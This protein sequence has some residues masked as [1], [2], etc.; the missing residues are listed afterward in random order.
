MYFWIQLLCILVLDGFNGM[1]IQSLHILEAMQRYVRWFEC[2]GSNEVGL[3][4][5]PQTNLDSDV[6]EVG[7]LIVSSDLKN[8][9][10]DF[11]QK[12]CN[13]FNVN[14]FFNTLF[15]FGKN[16]KQH[17]RNFQQCIQIYVYIYYIMYICYVMLCYVM[18]C[19][20]MLCYVMLCYVMLCY[21]MLCYVMLCYVMLC[22]VMLCYVYVMLCYVMLCYVIQ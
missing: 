10:P 17:S 7:I 20:V 3:A 18:L 9:R 6:L 19:Y 5:A 8:W 14:I 2:C 11:S 16:P 1:S 12:N 21:V 15:S 13:K 22:Y 4:L